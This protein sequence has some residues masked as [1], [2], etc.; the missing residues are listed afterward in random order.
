M[1]TG[2]N[3]DTVSL[4][5]RGIGRTIASHLCSLGAR[6]VINYA[7]SSAQAD[8]VAAELNSS[9]SDP[10]VPPRATAVKADISEPD[11]VKHL[12]DEAERAFGSPAHIFVNCAGVADPKYPSLADT[13]VEDWDSTF[14]VNAR[15]AFLRCREAANRLRCGGGG[16]IVMVT[17]SLVGGL[18]P[19][20]SAYTASKA[21]VETM[22]KIAAKELK[23][24]GITANCVAPGPVATELFFAGTTEE[25]VKRVVDACP[26]GRL[27]EGKDVAEVVGFLAS[28]AGEW[29]NGQVIRV[30]GGFV[31]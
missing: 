9:D 26:L 6:V 16:R 18:L 8:A 2:S 20:Y 13:T 7:S 4:G 30:N 15:G 28:D 19:G 12:F 3:A 31:I 5:S 17:T 10:S 22:T 21:A 14:K 24:T 11:Q 25:M 27:G 1:A 23:G 29:V